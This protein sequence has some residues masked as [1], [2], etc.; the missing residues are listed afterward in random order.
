MCPQCPTHCQAEAQWYLRLSHWLSVLHPSGASSAPP[1]Q[2]E[3]SKEE[4]ARQNELTLWKFSTL[5]H[6]SEF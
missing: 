2:R 3:L 6:Y 4:T 1:M 5:L